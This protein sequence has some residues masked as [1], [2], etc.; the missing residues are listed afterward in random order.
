M[1]SK[2]N[3]LYSPHQEIV[4]KTDKIYLINPS[5]AEFKT[6]YFNDKNERVEITLAPLETRDFPIGEGNTILKH[7][8][9]FILN[10]GGFSYKTDV[11]IEK[12]KIRQKCIVYE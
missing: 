10:Q 5:V 12:E 9:D 8:V 4:T 11:N 7:L 6:S 3:N 1:N 2:R